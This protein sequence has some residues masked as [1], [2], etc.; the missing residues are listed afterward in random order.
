MPTQ[1][2]LIRAVDYNDVQ[3]AVAR[4]LNDRIGNF[5]GDPARATY[6]Y[7][8]AML[9]SSVVV[10]EPASHTHLELLR[11]D[12]LKIARHCGVENNPAITNVPTIPT[13]GILIDNDHLDKFQ[14]AVNY[15]NGQRFSL[16]A[17]QYSDES[18]PTNISHSRTTPWGVSNT[19]V[20][21]NGGN[22]V[23]HAFTVDFG[24]SNN[25]RYFF[26]S[27][28]E[29]RFSASRTGGTNS[30]NNQS[31]TTLLSSMGTIRFNYSSTTATGSGAGSAIGFYQLT[32]APQQVFT[33]SAGS[34]YVYQT[35]YTPNDYTITVHSDVPNNSLGTARYLYVNVYFNDDHATNVYTND[36]VNGT[37]TSTVGIRR[38]TGPNV[39]VPAPNA[40][41]TVLLSY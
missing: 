19:Y 37:L 15:L 7:G 29:I 30:F 9:S 13:S 22:T 11:L 39:Q 28:G 25:A 31:W 38:A 5:T 32:N 23:R 40:I 4:L 34:V 2:A 3:T 8:Q 17:D 35:Q 21:G 20:Y 26:N 18:F 12:I 14:L 16:G 10:G 36:V 33:K 27:G 24:N 1:G 6:G 41:N